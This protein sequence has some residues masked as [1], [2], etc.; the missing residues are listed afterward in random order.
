MLAVAHKASPPIIQAAKVKVYD[1]NKLIVD[2]FAGGG[3][4]SSGLKQAM[5]RDVDVAINHNADA[6][7]MHLVN[8]PGARHY[9]AD[10]WEVDPFEAT[11]GMPVGWL[12]ASPDCFPAGTMVLTRDGYRAIEQVQVGDEVLT[13]KQ[14]WRRVKDTMCAVRPL[15][16][17]RGQGH[18][19]LLVSPEHPFYTRQRRDVWQTSPRGYQRTLGP[20]QW[21]AARDL[22][23]G[24]YWAT[25]CDFPADEPP[26]IPVYR[27]RTLKADANLLWLAGLY[28]ADG[29]TRLKDGRAE[30]V[31]T[32]GRHEVERLRTALNQWPRK[33]GRCVA[34]ELTWHER[35][36]S[37]AYQ[38]ATDHRGLVEWLRQHFGHGAADKLIPGWALGMSQDLREAFLAGYL[39]GDDCTPKCDGT[40]LVIC[41]TVSKA[42]AF[43]L[44]G[45]AGS[46]GYSPAVY[47]RT[48]QP[49][50]IQGRKVNVLPAWSVRW[51]PEPEREQSFREDGLNWAPI[52]ETEDLEVLATVFNLSVED[53]ESYIAEGVVVHNCTH[54]S[55]ALGGQPREQEVRS[56][57]WV[58]H[59]WAGL[60]RPD[61]IS[62]ENV[63]QMLDWSPLIAKRCKVT[64][65][66]ITLDKI[67][68]PD[69]K[70]TF[71][72]ADPGEQVPRRNQFL[73][74]D[75]KH[76]GRNWGHF[77]Q[78]L[79]DMG[80]AVQWRVI[81][82]ADLG[83]HSTRERLYLIA[84]RD[85]LP[86]VWPQQT[87]AKAPR[88][89]LKRWRPVSECIDWSVHGNSIFGRKKDL[90]SATLRRIAH[91]MRKFVLESPDPFIVPAT[92]SDSSNRNRPVTEPIPTITAA[93]R[94]ELMLSAPAL[95]PV[96]HTRD[97]AFDTREPMRTITT[98]KG[99]ETALMSAALVQMGHGEGKDGG[100]RWSHGANDI[101]GP[102]GSIT[103]SGAG[104]GLGAAFMVQANGGFNTTHARDLREPAST[105]TTTGSQQ[106]FIAA[107]L[108]TL[109]HHSTGRELHEPIATVAAGG[110]HHGLVEYRLSHDDLSGALRCADFLHLHRR[111]KGGDHSASEALS[112]AQRL[113][114]VTVWVNGE[115]FVVVDIRLRMLLPRE[116]YNA[117]DF[118]SDYVIDRTADGKVLSKTAQVR[119]CGNS[120]SPLPMRL[121]V[122]CNRPD[123][124]GA[125]AAA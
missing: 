93:N 1:R 13:H 121:L 50:V 98:A 20:A 119:M 103:A 72:V 70:K 83:A 48:N 16:R 69:G 84:R 32:C 11:G 77:V 56:L 87:H 91:G 17:I 23:R 6:I 25:P 107:H 92:H 34:D 94:G 58:V 76:K 59:R 81:R 71:R 104:Q 46:L 85:G 101:R 30:L 95:V 118:P 117:Q 8:H 3:G 106:Q 2:L 60:A 22:G 10:V 39:S 26:P 44:K 42:L 36:T 78:G 75:P 18:P 86:I 27:S 73:V 54:H 74:P 4:A 61:V 29:W 79:R 7:G 43:G 15:M 65:R 68:G 37:T 120:V 96:T 64:G 116:L 14:R 51:R 113:Q 31:I 99:G 90:A 33:G 57:A 82:N 19:G 88:A 21:T 67:V 28:V 123:A 124:Q 115:P 55:Q 9:I 35:E 89:G 52:R 105:V 100:A 47:I 108:T 112:D 62:L 5:G 102:V 41:T 53:D 24:S 110:E 109:R 49:D 66:V 63:E 80:Y 38:F 97:T 122:A 12:H 111:D 114:M 45:L 125:L 40:R